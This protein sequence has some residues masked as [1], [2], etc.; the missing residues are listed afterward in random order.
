MEILSGADQRPWASS[1]YWNHPIVDNK[2]T[3]HLS[4]LWRAPLIGAKKLVNNI[5]ID[6]AR[7]PDRGKSWHSMRGQ[8]FKLPITQ[9]NSET[10]W[11][12]SPGS[13]LINQTSMALDGNGHPHIAFYADD[14]DGIPQYQHLYFDGRIWR[15]NSISV[16]KKRFALRGGGTLRLPISRPEI[17]IDWADRVYVI[18]RGDLTGNLMAIQRLLP[19]DYQADP[20]DIRILWH[21]QLG[22]SEP[23]VDRSRWHRHGILSMLIQKN[24]QPAHDKYSPPQYRSAY[25]ADWDLT[26][27]EVTAAK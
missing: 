15:N 17:L 20:A 11:P 8:P 1:P 3:L 18:Y 6:Y 4:F 5:G 23:V 13:N 14:P 2:G 12:I 9:V 21:E 19:P 24:N 27:W 26:D 10:I 25:I 22:F 16:R 7:S